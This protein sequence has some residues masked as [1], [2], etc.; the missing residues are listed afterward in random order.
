[1]LDPISEDTKRQCLNF[2][3]GLPDCAPIRKNAGEFKY[4]SEPSSITFLFEFDCKRHR[5]IPDAS[6]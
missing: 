5:R 2:A 6:F 3:D 4:F 1:M